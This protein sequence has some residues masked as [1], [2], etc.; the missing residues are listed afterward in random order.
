MAEPNELV[1]IARFSTLPEMDMARGLLESEG[2]DCLA[3]EEH[4][5]AATGGIY[6]QAVGWLRLQVRT[7]D[8]ERAKAL[9]ESL[10][11]DS[12]SNSEEED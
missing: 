12:D 11:A 6:G 1:T 7:E 3:P 5:V 8:V 2:I 9:L 4:L 10:P